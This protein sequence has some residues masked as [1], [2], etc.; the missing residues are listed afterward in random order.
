MKAKDSFREKQKA[1]RQIKL[2]IDLAWALHRSVVHDMT[3][4]DV[5]DDEMD[6]LIYFLIDRGIINDQT[7]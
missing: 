6:K 2:D 1:L 3:G 5:G 7:E 4:G